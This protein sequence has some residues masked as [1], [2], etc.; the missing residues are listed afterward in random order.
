M[1]VQP[2]FP[3]GVLPG[4]ITTTDVRCDRFDFDIVWTVLT[5]RCDDVRWL[6][7]TTQLHLRGGRRDVVARVLGVREPERHE[8]FRGRRGLFIFDTF[9]MRQETASVIAWGTS[10]CSR[11]LQ[12]YLKTCEPELVEQLRHSCGVLPYSEP[13]QTSTGVYR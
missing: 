7:H 10:R 8:G 11:A 13:P 5:I 4:T 1:T 2:D 9:D 3:I 6:E 12:D